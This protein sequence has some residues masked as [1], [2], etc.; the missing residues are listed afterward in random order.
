MSQHQIQQDRDTAPNPTPDPFP[1]RPVLP[2]RPVRRLL[3]V[4]TAAIGSLALAAPG[5][6][7][8]PPSAQFDGTYTCSTGQSFEIFVSEHSQVGY[9][10]GRGVAPRAFHFTST[11]VLVVQDGLYAGD[12]ITADVDSGVTGLN[13]QPIDDRTL[14]GTATCGQ[15][16]SGHVDFVVDE[17]TVGFFGI[18]PKYLGATVGGTEDA[19]ITIYVTAEQLANR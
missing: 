17:L 11:L 14:N 13:K 12:V 3:L 19:S 2:W 5:A 18:D 9:V 6:Q 4:V 16:F 7:A 1:P 8:G 10:D 15:T